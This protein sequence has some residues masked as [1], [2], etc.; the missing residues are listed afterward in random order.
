MP[1][2][3]LLTVASLLNSSCERGG[4]AWAGFL[5]GDSVGQGPGHPGA[6]SCLML[7]ASPWGE[8][9]SQ[10]CP[11]RCFGLTGRGAGRQGGGQG[12]EG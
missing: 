3:R 9:R 7:P 2:S 1:T 12:R 6:L 10:P 8:G 11:A 4:L 5:C